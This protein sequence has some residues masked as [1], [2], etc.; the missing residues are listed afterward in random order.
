MTAVARARDA[1]PLRLGIVTREFPL[2]SETF[3]IDQAL[4]Q[5]RHGFRIDLIADRVHDDDPLALANADV[6]RLVASATHRRWRRFGPV[7]AAARPL[8]G[9]VRRIIEACADIEAD[10]RLGAY[11]ILLGHFG[12]IGMRLARSRALG[13]F[14]A[15]FAT[16]FH[17]NDVALSMR[18]GTLGRFR[19]LFREADLLL[20]VSGF[21]REVLVGAGAAPSR[22]IVHRTGVDCASVPFEPVR[23]R[24]G[25]LIF[26]TACRF[27]EKKGIEF[28]I[29]AVRELASGRPDLDWRY[30]I[31]GD[32]PLRSNL[33]TL[34]RQ[35]GLEQRVIFLGALPHAG[36]KERLARAHAF[37][38]P[39][40]TAA[41]GDMEGIPVALMEAM[42]AGLPVVSSFH[43]GIPELVQHEA[44]GLLA[45]ERDVAGLAACL[46]WVADHPEGCLRMAEHARAFV[47]AHFDQA[48]L[49]DRL[50]DM[51]RRAATG[52]P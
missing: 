39:S 42:A 5:E 36:V 2:L 22:T 26:T 33:E 34:T 28:A 20:P 8:P 19:Q 18:N 17:G 45:A 29:R 15:P 12:D 32:G 40:V 27:V 10:G 24:S 51:L 37:L 38:L 4:A 46:A 49:N 25:Q 3:V 30:E 47:E 9:R 13:R 43:S 52:A 1:S 14:H 35:L 50:A 21:F 48:K 11:D 44:T 41:N 23:D 7:V 31:V 16:I 6:A